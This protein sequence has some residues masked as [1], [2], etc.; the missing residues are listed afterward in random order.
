MGTPEN[1]TAQDND[2]LGCLVITIVVTVVTVLLG[3]YL[4][5]V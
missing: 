4:A 5:P 2:A 3:I 1:E